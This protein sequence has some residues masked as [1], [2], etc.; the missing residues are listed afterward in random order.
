V[1]WVVWVERCGLEVVS[2]EVEC[3]VLELDDGEAWECADGVEED[4]ED[5]AGVSWLGELFGWD[6]LVGVDGG[7]VEGFGEGDLGLDDGVCDEH[8]VMLLVVWTET[9]GVVRVAQGLWLR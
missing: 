9:E 7:S 4:G 6:A 1:G 3:G 5:C 2:C 8:G